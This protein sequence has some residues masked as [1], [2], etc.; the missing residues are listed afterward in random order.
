MWV[1]TVLWGYLIMHE[2]FMELAKTC[3]ISIAETTAKA[4]LAKHP[5]ITDEVSLY[6][7]APSLIAEAVQ[8][9]HCNIK[10]IT[11]QP[12][13]VY[14]QLQETGRYQPAAGCMYGQRI[15]CLALNEKT[16]QQL[17]HTAPTMPQIMLV[18]EVSADRVTRID[19]VDWV[20]RLNGF[21]SDPPSFTYCEYTLDYLL[22]SDVVDI[23]KVSDSSDVDTVQDAFLDTHYPIVEEASGYRWRRLA[24][25]DGAPYAQEDYDNCVLKIMRLMVPQFVAI[26]DLDVAEVEEQVCKYFSIEAYKHV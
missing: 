23:Q 7:F 13:K 4:I 22:K 8:K 26:T 6:K 25:L 12:N 10:L 15:F 21:Q 16:M 3:S 17:F 11:F 1:K 5:E 18:L 19:Y 9:E 2:V 14:E 20:N 24:D